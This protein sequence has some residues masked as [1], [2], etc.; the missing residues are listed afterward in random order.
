MSEPIWSPS[1]ARV[2]QSNLSAFAEGLK[3]DVHAP[4]YPAL[5][6]W[7][8]Q[9]PEQFWPAVVDFCRLKLSA[10]QQ[11]LLDGDRMPG[12]RW[13]QGSQLNFAE[14]LLARAGEEGPAIIAHDESGRRREFSGDQLRAEVARVAAGLRADGVGV[15]DRVAA[16]LPNGPEALI[17]M[18]AATSL[19]AVWSSCSP[20]FGFNGVLD[21]FGQIEPKV[22]LACDGYFYNGKRV[23]TR[24]RI[25][26]IVNA[27]PKLQ[28]LL[29]VPFM[30]AEPDLELL[31]DAARFDLYGDPAAALQFT[32][33]DFDH[34]LY[35]MFSSGTTGKPKCI[36]HGT[37]GTLLQHAKELVLQT[38]V[39]PGD[40][41]FFFTT[42]GWMMWNWLVSGL[43]AGATVVLYDGSPFA[44][45]PDCLWRLAQAERLNQMGISP[46]FLSA[47]Q[48]AGYVPQ[49]AVDLSALRTMLSTGSPLAPEGF[50]FV[51]RQVKDDLQLASI[52][53]GTD[54][55]SCFVLGNPW[56]PVH[57]GELQ[58]AGLGMAADIFDD[59][60]Q[61]VAEGGGELVCTQPFPSMPVS[62]WNDAD[63]SRYR[64]AYFETYPNTWHHG[65]Y[66]ERGTDGGFIIQGRSDATLNPGGIRIGTAE[67]YR[68]VEAI[69]GVLESIAVGYRRDGD[70][71][72]VLFVRLVEGVELDAVLTQRIRANI[73]AE[74]T[75]RHVPAKVLA[76]PDIP[77]TI[78]GK[79][80]EIAVR[81]LIHGREVKNADALANPQALE[82]FRKLQ[83]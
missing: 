36:V 53:G 39:Q 57:R 59:H 52:S 17:G 21:R 30:D 49:D 41:L 25:A 58:G 79:I 11:V 83:L 80:T 70:E 61:S 65:D 37:G 68:V 4:D 13:Y 56:Q 51:Y 81:D 31:P 26:K 72:V 62:F 20:D 76:C 29:V 27:L 8:V 3:L 10:P 16:F 19:G 28:R 24:E 45:G 35:I 12:A 40:R 74:L 64:K 43:V 2:A 48:Q 47:V 55:I 34:P 66:A 63:G 5:W 75:P 1:A 54:I 60:G 71:E 38:D 78:S 15:G 33:V 44:G 7:S 77:R 9:Q 69:D 50:D 42:C 46:K 23:D 73:R 18:L 82:F 67:I 14:N 22:L 32:S 6:R